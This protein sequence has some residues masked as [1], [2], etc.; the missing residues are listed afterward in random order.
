MDDGGK[1]SY[2]QTVLHTRSFSKKDVEYIQ[3]I[4]KKTLV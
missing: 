3:S 4:L 2:G 1:S